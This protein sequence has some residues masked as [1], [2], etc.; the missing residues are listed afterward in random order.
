MIRCRA[1]SSIF[2]AVFIRSSAL[3]LP[4]HPGWSNDAAETQSCSLLANG[5]ATLHHITS[6]PT[7]WSSWTVSREIWIQI[8]NNW[9]WWI[10]F[11]YFILCC[12][13]NSWITLILHFRVSS[14]SLITWPT[15]RSNV[16]HSFPTGGVILYAGSCGSASPSPGSPSSGYQS[17]SPSSHSQPSSPEDFTF[18]E[19]GA[20]K[21]GRAAGCNT[22][23]S[24]LVFQFPEVY[25]NPSAAATPQHSYAHPIAA[26]RPCS[27]AGTFTS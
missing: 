5:C 27:F 12:R 13:C 20:L 14:Q 10:Y 17:Q 18:T 26:K 21:Q 24:K 22:P 2:S 15:L 11:C 23:S 9:K 8:C 19:I 6:Y 16:L 4:L 7:R 1:A 3:L 25:S